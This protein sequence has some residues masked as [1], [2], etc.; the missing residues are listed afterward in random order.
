MHNS[1]PWDPWLPVVENSLLFAQH[2]HSARCAPPKST[3]RPSI[4]ML[5]PRHTELGVPFPQ[6]QENKA[7][8]YDWKKWW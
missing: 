2:G 8:M 7:F 1:G 4:P 6:L 3:F 5:Y